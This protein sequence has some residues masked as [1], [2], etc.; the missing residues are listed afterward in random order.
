[1]NLIGSYDCQCSDGFVGDGL[2]CSDV[3]ECMS[4][5]N[6]TCVYTQGSY[7]CT[8]LDGFDGN[9]LTC[10]DDDEC[11]EESALC[12]HNCDPNAKCFNSVGG[13]SKVM[14]IHVLI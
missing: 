10:D 9:G 14:E 3:D 5:R 11:T 6:A 8:C 12:V 13:V 4:Y 2:T 1:M 7:D